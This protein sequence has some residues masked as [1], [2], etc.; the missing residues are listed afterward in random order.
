MC[1]RVY[2]NDVPHYLIY[3]MGYLC[4]SQDFVLVSQARIC[5]CLDIG[6]LSKYVAYSANK[7]KHSEMDIVKQFF[8]SIIALKL[9]KDFSR[10][11]HV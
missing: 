10:V 3:V 1:T 7:L 8:F 2:I 4:L 11:P 5:W 6:N 9:N